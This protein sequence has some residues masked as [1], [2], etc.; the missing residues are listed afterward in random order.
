MPNPYLT[1]ELF[2]FLT[3][4]K[5]NN[6]R[7]WFNDNKSRYEQF[8]KEPLLDLIADF[9]PFLAEISP[10]FKAIPSANGGSLFRI[11][12]DVRF[13]KNKDPYKTHAAIHFR[14][15]LGKDAHAPGYYLHVEPGNV[16]LGMGI[17]NPASDA[18]R[19]VRLAIDSNPDEWEAIINSAEF[20]Q[21]YELKGESLKRPPKGFD[22]EHPCIEDLKRKDFM[23]VAQFDEEVAYRPDLLP[24]LSMIW[25]SGSPF[26]RFISKAM[27]V[28][29]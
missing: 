4:L 17:W 11:Y 16:F 20:S 2:S 19:Q 7:D 15:S 1:P 12:R 8:V 13:S 29:F 25:Q 18:L 14:H 24:F 28:S 6:D 3:E 9:S 22:P 5:S 10:H 27:D 23:G 21:T 26:M